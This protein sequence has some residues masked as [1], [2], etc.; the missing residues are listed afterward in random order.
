M[1]T[2]P[3]SGAIFR[4]HHSQSVLRSCQRRRRTQGR[5]REELLL[6]LCTSSQLFDGHFQAKGN[7]NYAVVMY[8][9]LI[10]KLLL[11]S[12]DCCWTLELCQRRCGTGLVC[13]DRLARLLSRLSIHSLLSSS[14]LQNS[15]N[16]M[17]SWSV[18]DSL[19]N[20]LLHRKSNLVLVD[21][22]E[23]NISY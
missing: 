8:R 6:L 7:S 15:I 22:Q 19:L 1:Q 23:I 13:S 10:V 2:Y 4:G 17:I 14:S 11:F 3:I 16:D 21:K 18:L 20:A 9:Q 5:E 12:V